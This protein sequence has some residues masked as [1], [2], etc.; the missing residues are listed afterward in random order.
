MIMCSIQHVL[1]ANTDGWYLTWGWIVKASADICSLCT[2]IQELFVFLLLCATMTIAVKTLE[3]QWVLP[4]LNRRKADL[5]W[6][7][8][9]CLKNSLYIWICLQCK[10]ADLLS[11][12]QQILFLIFLDTRTPGLHLQGGGGGLLCSRLDEMS[13]QLG[14]L[15][16]V[17]KSVSPVCLLQ[18]RKDRC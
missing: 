12:G 11:C 18:E 7:K 13:K 3:Q 5:T 2:L 4:K 15:Q 6:Q 9:F 1:H 10:V 16:K 8:S 17:L 14:L